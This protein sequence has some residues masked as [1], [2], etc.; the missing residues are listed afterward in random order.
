MSARAAAARVAIRAADGDVTYAELA[1]R[2]AR[3]GNALLGLGLR[4]GERLL[5]VVKDCPEFFY[6]FWGA[7]KAGIVPVP[8]NTLLRADD[9]RYMIEDSGCAALAW[10]AGVRRR[11]AGRAGG[12]A[13]PPRPLPAGGRRR[14]ERAGADR[15]R[16]RLRS[17]RP[18]PRR[19][20]MR[21]GCIP[22]APPGGRKGRCTGTAAWW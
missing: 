2:V 15:L 1:E 19:R 21:S 8:L 17:P 7:I 6:L 11:G 12:G 20:R 16:A 4:R 3:C 10:S 22:R 14:R 18:T 13:A 5:M 9:Y